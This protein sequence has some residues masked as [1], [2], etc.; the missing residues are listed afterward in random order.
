MRW[1]LVILKII[2]KVISENHSESD[3]Y[4]IKKEI[5]NI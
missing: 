1:S 5:I 3:H 4:S 2:Q